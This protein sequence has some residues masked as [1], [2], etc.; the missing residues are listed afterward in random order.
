MNWKKLIPIL[1]ILLPGILYAFIWAFLIAPLFPMQEY[2]RD[3]LF[4]LLK[5]AFLT[6]HVPRDAG[7]LRIL[8]E[9]T[10]LVVHASLITWIAII[11]FSI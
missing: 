7:D 10:K 5:Q 6:R 2:F 8:T 9:A 1:I 4:H 3:R 11:V